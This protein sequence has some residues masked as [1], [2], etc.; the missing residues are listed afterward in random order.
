MYGLRGV[1]SDR[2]PGRRER[3]PFSG[4]SVLFRSNRGQASCPGVVVTLLSYLDV[5]SLELSSDIFRDLVCEL[6]SIEVGLQSC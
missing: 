3:G 2:S 1:S 4:R 6:A 5:I